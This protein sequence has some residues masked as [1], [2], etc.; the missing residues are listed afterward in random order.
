MHDWTFLDI[1][2]CWLDKKCVIRFKNRNSETEEVCGNG[3]TL[4]NVPHQEEWGPSVS[5]N[6]ITYS[7]MPDD[8]NELKIEMQSGDVITIQA[9]SFSGI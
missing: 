4:L 9:I 7:K 5:V 8:I 2:Y 3:V 6:E 1:K